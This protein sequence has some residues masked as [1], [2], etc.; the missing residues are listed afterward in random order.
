MRKT[1][2][3]NLPAGLHRCSGVEGKLSPSANEH[4]KCS[5]ATLSRRSQWP[6]KIRRIDR[7]SEREDTAQ[8]MIA[9]STRTSRESVFKELFHQKRVREH[10]MHQ[11]SHGWPQGGTG[12]KG[13]V[14]YRKF[15]KNAKTNS[16]YIFITSFT[17]MAKSCYTVYD[18]ITL[19]CSAVHHY[20]WAHIVKLSEQKWNDKQ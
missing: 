2:L 18:F 17:C 15:Y 4:L 9:C 16:E 13:E 12:K 5:S 14:W 6:K 7:M 3:H 1:V 11:V 8:S 19:Q 20:R 10:Y